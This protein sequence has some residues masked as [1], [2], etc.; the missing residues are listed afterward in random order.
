[1]QPLQIALRFVRCALT[2]AVLGTVATLATAQESSLRRLDSRDDTRGWE[3]VGQLKLGGHGFCTGALI[4]EDLV[5]TAGHCL[6]DKATGAPIDPGAIQF[7]AGWRNGKAEAYRAIKRAVSHPDYVYQAAPD[8]AMVRFDVAILQ[9]SDPIRDGVVNPFAVDAQPV[10]GAEVGVVSY[11]HDR[12]D[13]P[14][15][16]RVCRVRDRMSEVLV[17]SC[18]VDFG[19]SGSPVFSFGYGRPR[20]VAVVS[21]KATMGGEKVSLAAD[22]DEVLPVLKARL[23]AE[24]GLPQAGQGAARVSTLGERRTIGA[25]FIRPGG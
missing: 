25:K 6:F 13:A 16:Q 3:A 2:F 22:L 19:A 14:S 12:S 1:M 23:R 15:L 8:P 7:L 9:L 17:M 10:P 11:A 21:A 20:I 18:A 24:I 5:L 4:A